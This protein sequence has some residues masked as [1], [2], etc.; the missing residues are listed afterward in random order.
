MGALPVTT[1]ERQQNQQHTPKSSRNTW[2]P[3]LASNQKEGF[4]PHVAHRAQVVAA[5]QENGPNEPNSPF[6]FNNILEKRTHCALLQR[7]TPV[8]ESPTPGGFGMPGYAR[9]A[10]KRRRLGTGGVEAFRPSPQIGG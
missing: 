6:V 3:M 8:G 5:E 9:V 1:P 10:E 4:T 7:G 2:E